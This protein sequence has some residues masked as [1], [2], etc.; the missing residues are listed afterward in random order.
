MK[1]RKQS[2]KRGRNGNIEIHQ[3]IN[4]DNHLGTD[5][6][7]DIE[8]VLDMEAASGQKRESRKSQKNH[9]ELEV[10]TVE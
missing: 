8:D 1:E 3:E 5:L 10:V 2:I 6:D 4:Q 9:E 7:L